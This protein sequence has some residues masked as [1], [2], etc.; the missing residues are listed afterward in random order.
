[1]PY[2]PTPST[3]TTQTIPLRNKKEGK[4][5]ER[6][7]KSLLPRSK[8]KKPVMMRCP[9]SCTAFQCLKPGRLTLFKRDPLGRIGVV[10]PKELP[11][12]F[13]FGVAN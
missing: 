9:E 5:G 4:K 6:W 3:I 13:F 10:W 11:V 7:K 12:V 8:K 1:M 2:L